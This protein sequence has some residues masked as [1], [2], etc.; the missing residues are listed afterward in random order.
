[1]KKTLFSGRH[2]V[3]FILIFPIKPDISLLASAYAYQKARS[4]PIALLHLPIK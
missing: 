1:M 3:P 4:A 2:T